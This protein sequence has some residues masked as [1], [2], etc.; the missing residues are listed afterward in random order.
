MIESD[1]KLVF[2]NQLRGIA[3]LMVMISHLGLVFWFARDVVA[4]YIFA[5]SV[6]GPAPDILRWITLPT[7]NFGPLGVAIFFL[8]SGFVIPFSLHRA[9]T[10][11]F[12]VARF[13]R[14]F[15]T[16]WI[17]TALSL[18]VVYAS[19][20]Y[21]KIPM[22]LSLG[23]LG[24]NF[25][26]MQ[27][28]FQVP[29]IDLVN[30]T[31]SVEVKFYLISAVLAF[32]IR[33]FSVV[34]LL[35]FG[36]FSLGF[37]ELLPNVR[38]I[39]SLPPY[40]VSAEAEKVEFM[41]IN[42]MFIGTLFNYFHLKNISLK[43]FLLSVCAL[44]FLFIL[45][46]AHTPWASQ[47][48]QTPLNYFYGLIIFTV[49]FSCRYRFRSIRLIDFLADISFPLYIIHSLCGY[50]FIRILLD[51]KLSYPAAFVIAIIIV[52]FLAYILHVFVEVPF[53]KLGRKF[54]KNLQE[55]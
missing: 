50:T 2:A 11:G 53:S 36:I 55:K 35:L 26:L 20:N 6:I 1:N 5:P 44:F 12:L 30:W 10:K 43:I 24:I 41:C 49:A 8:I 22:K 25:A 14:I 15:P 19:S 17:S 3:V 38:S 7:V 21:W 31:L 23:T 27:I 29:S 4:S 13:F 16:Y 51:L 9:A 52:F 28:P 54:S 39:L 34:P 42:F 45:T 33:R 32:S 46:W 18:F 40:T 47:V 48:P 37:A